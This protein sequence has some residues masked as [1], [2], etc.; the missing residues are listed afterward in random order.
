MMSGH[1]FLSNPGMPKEKEKKKWLATFEMLPT[2][3][4]TGI[5]I[6]MV[7]ETSCVD[8]DGLT[9]SD[10]CPFHPQTGSATVSPGVLPLPGVLFLEPCC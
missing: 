9:E 4:P 6:V 7:F 5:V 10:H 8:L 3:D 2:S 1:H